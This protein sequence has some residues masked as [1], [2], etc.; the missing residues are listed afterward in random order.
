M[1][2]GSGIVWV[3]KIISEQKMGIVKNWYSDVIVGIFVFFFSS[4]IYFSVEFCWIWVLN[5][6]LE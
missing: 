1:L 6:H 4:P 3:G 2:D 5:V